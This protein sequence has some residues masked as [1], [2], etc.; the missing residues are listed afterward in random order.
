MHGSV[1]GV[2][3][4]GREQVPVALDKGGQV[5]ARALLLAFEEELDVDP[6]EL[7]QIV[8]QL[9]RQDVGEKLALVVADAPGIDAPVADRR[10]K[11]QANPLL[12]RFGRLDVVVA[13]DQDRVGIV[14]S[15]PLAV[16]DRQAVGRHDPRR[17][18]VLGQDC[19]DEFG[20]FVHADPLRTDRR[21]AEEAK[22]RFEERF[23]P[24]TNLLLN[25]RR[26][27]HMQIL[28]S[29]WASL[30]GRRCRGGGWG[31]R[32]TATHARSCVADL[33][34][35]VASISPCSTRFRSRISFVLRKWY[36]SLSPFIDGSV[37]AG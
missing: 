20:A 11:R 17:D 6:R 35:S 15:D 2:E 1:G 16:D 28:P 18:A 25:H 37:A 26:G 24:R 27:K 4:I 36:S 21:L 12:E 13:V 31:D 29:R 32:P 34:V 19:R 23:P 30:T 3:E 9:D 7:A 5:R 22:Q 10:L 33:A 14:A 8:E